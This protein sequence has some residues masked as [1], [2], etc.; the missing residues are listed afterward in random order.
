MNYR[1]IISGSRS[2]TELRHIYDA[3]KASGFSPS[4]VISGTCRG[5][6]RFGEEWAKA[7]GVPIER[8][9]ADWNQ[10]GK[11]AGYIRNVDMACHAE[12]LIAVWDGE[13]NGTRH[14]INAARAKGLK[15][16]VYMFKEERADMKFDDLEQECLACQKC[17]IGG[18]VLDGKPATVLSNGNIK[19]KI[20]VVGQNPGR[21]EVSQHTPFIGISGKIFDECLEANTVLKREDLYICNSVCCLRYN[22]KV[23]L[24]DGSYKTIS[25]MVREKYSGE[26]M[27]ISQSGK[28]EKRRVTNWYKNDLGTRKCYKLSY[29]NAKRN[30]RGRSGPTLTEDHPVLTR[31]GYKKVSDLSLEDEIA[32]GEPSP[33]IVLQDIIYGSM[34]GDAHISTRYEESHCIR[35]KSYSLFKKECLKSL[36]AKSWD[37]YSKDGHHQSR[38]YTSSSR[39]WR[40]LREKFYP[41][42]KKEIMFLETLNPLIVAIW[43]MDDGNL[44]KFKNRNPSMCFSTNSFEKKGVE[45]LCSL[46]S[47]FSGTDDIKCIKSNGWRIRVGAKGT[48]KIAA[49]IAEYILPVFRY[50]LPEMFRNIPFH[51]VSK[52]CKSDQNRWEKNL[53]KTEVEY[54][55]KSVYC[56]D[57]EKN[58]NFIVDG[59]IVVHNCFTPENRKP[60][61]LEFQNCSDFLQK[62]IDL[63]K[64]VV[65]VTLGGVALRALTGLNGITKY[66]AKPVFSYKYKVTVFPLLHP[67]PLNTNRPEKKKEFCDGL[68]ALNTF[69]ANQC[70]TMS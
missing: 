2:C 23:L 18:Q 43:Y 6:D 28:L 55:E 64:P 27:T 46:L 17:K 4:V 68:K 32:I 10:Y 50:K 60:T 54:P 14:M 35:H 65:V 49:K 19:A 24:G 13:S 29:Q 12:A 5:P 1:T 66:H 63:V 11:Q 8:F 48:E 9:P 52:K 3:V 69:I 56:I 53:L 34:L 45:H 61:E 59:G 38:I 39:F 40:S 31:T 21:D 70:Q 37:F 44:T 20:M 25:Q 22:C 57:V 62:Q 67:S 47:K 51:D 41:H 30:N 33:N 36:G 58:H 15:V 16:F 26:V 42:G 7:N